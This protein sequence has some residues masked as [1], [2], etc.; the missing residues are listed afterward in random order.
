M[1]LKSRD[2]FSVRG[3]GNCRIRLLEPTVDASYSNVGNLEETNFKAIA[4]MENI[5]DENGRLQ[6]SLVQGEMVGIDTVLQQSSKSEFDLIRQAANKLYAL[7]YYGM[8]NPT[9]FQYFCLEQCVIDPTLNAPFKKGKRL[10]PL[11]ALS[12][13][14]ESGALV[15]PQYYL[16]QGNGRM[17]LEACY[18][19]LSPRSIL[20]ESG[21]V[22]LFDISGFQKHAALTLSAMWI[23]GTPGADP[24]KF[25]RLNGTD[26]IIT[27]PNGISG[28]GYLSFD[29]WFRNKASSGV[30]QLM[31]IDDGAGTTLT[32]THDAF[33]IPKV[34]SLAYADDTALVTDD[35]GI[36][37][38]NN[39]WAHMFVHMT[40]T[41]FKTFINGVQDLNSTGL[42]VQGFTAAANIVLGKVSTNYGQDDFS[43]FRVH[44]DLTDTQAA[45]IALAHYNAEKGSHG[46]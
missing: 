12:I 26:Q 46:L 27:I 3:L 19:W 14:K 42:T 45:E 22:T 15:Y 30:Q 9:M 6:Q 13:V 16:A 37:I 5:K 38:A 24:E 8:A 21:T 2:L 29:F 41:T 7:Q 44:K 4:E 20:T 10:V 1:N 18:V 34:I 23:A 31:S 28:A 43:D 17:Y 35:S 40:A 33:S 32:L 36:E 39:T 25:I 11:K